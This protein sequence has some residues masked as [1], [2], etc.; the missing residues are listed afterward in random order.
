MT[1]TYIVLAEYVN[2][3]GIKEN[4]QDVYQH[5]VTGDDVP[6]KQLI[7]CYMFERGQKIEIDLSTLTA[8][9]LETLCQKEGCYAIVRLNTNYDEEVRKQGLD[10]SLYKTKI[11]GL[12][13]IDWYNIT[14][15]EHV[16]NKFCLQWENQKAYIPNP[17]YSNWLLPLIDKFYLEVAKQ[18]QKKA[19]K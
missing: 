17:S 8:D 5:Y 16:I 6:R 18:N 13:K 7:P 12:N 19:T 9:Q 11:A 4:K 10:S 1:Q 14:L 3:N 15:P 2:L